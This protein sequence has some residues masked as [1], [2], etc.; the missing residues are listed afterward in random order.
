MFGILSCVSK[1]LRQVL[2]GV[3]QKAYPGKLDRC[4]FGWLG[5]VLTAV[6]GRVHTLP[7]VRERVWWPGSQ[8]CRG[9]CFLSAVWRWKAEGVPAVLGQQLGVCLPYGSRE[10]GACPPSPK[11]EQLWWRQ[12][13]VDGSLWEAWEQRAAEHFEAASS[14]IFSLATLWLSLSLYFYLNKSVLVHI[15]HLIFNV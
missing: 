14:K 9:A 11:Q 10:G 7:C 12:K 13:A 8:P 6:Q 5:V 15:P 1:N 4:W 2:D 3:C